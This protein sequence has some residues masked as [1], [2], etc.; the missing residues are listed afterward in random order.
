MPKPRQTTPDMTDQ[1]RFD[2][3]FAALAAAGV[4]Y[5]FD[6]RGATGVR[7]DRLHDY[8][9]VARCCGTARWVGEHVGITDTGG[10]Y[11]GLDGV[12]YGGRRPSTTHPIKEL[13]WSF[14]HEH[15][16]LADLLVALFRQQGIDAWWGG[17]LYDA[18][19]VNLAA[20][21]IAGTPAPALPSTAV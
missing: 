7:E 15:P 8:E 4:A 9:R 16:D 21:R 13:W 10:A 20:P 3:V 2:G 6:L 12:L 5:W 19:L 14:N 1:A 11:W 17:E 18:V